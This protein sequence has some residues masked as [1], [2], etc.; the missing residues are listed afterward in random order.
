MN[1]MK[2]KTAFTILFLTIAQ[3]MYSQEFNYGLRVGTILSQQT[4]MS[5]IFIEYG[6]KEHLYILTNRF[7]RHQSPK[8]FAFFSCKKPIL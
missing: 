2:L 4:L 1:S 6:I 7:S 5:S 3:N 8:N